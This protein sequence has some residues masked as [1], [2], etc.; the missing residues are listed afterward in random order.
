MPLYKVDH[1][2]EERTQRK[3]PDEDGFPHG[4]FAQI[5]LTMIFNAVLRLACYPSGWKSARIVPVLKLKK[6]HHSPKGYRSISL[7]CTISKVLETL[8]LARINDHLN[9]H[10]LLDNDQFGFRSGHSTTSQFFR[11]TNHVITAFNR[12][13]T[14]VMVPLNLERAFDKI[15]HE[16]LQ[17]KLKDCGRRPLEHTSKTGVSITL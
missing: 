2:Q 10:R 13:Q 14:A 9:E 1:Q 17:L 16:R 11:I 3:S 6:D 8:L 7:F 15:R 12:R 4:T 5:N